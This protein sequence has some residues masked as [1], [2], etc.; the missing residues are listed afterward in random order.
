MQ[1]GILEWILDK[2]K[3]TG[4][5]TRKFRIRNSG[6]FIVLCEHLLSAVNNRG[7]NEREIQEYSA[8][9]F[10]LFNV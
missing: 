7:N 5:E 2:E 6:K 4:G 9:V 3:D 10:Q 8:L 1:G